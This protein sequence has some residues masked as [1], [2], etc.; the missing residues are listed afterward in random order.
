MVA[1]A[2]QSAELS[3]VFKWL[4]ISEATRKTG[5]LTFVKLEKVKVPW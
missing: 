2:S 4:S 3:L 5:Q 1:V